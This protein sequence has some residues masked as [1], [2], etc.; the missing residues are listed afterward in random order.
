MDNRGRLYKPF[1]ENLFEA[2]QLSNANRFVQGPKQFFDDLSK[3]IVQP[4]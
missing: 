3:G 2:I 4:E 1:I